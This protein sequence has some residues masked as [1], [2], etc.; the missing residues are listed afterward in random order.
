MSDEAEPPPPGTELR[1]GGEFLRSFVGRPVT[2]IMG[3]LAALVFGL[4]SYGNLPLNLM[5]DL[6]YP[7]ITVRAEV[8]GAAPEEVEQTLARPLEEALSTVPGLLR[9]ESESRAGRCDVILEFDWKSDM[10]DLAQTVRERIGLVPLP[11]GVRRPLVL[12]YDPN[13]DPI[14]RIAL[15]GADD[16]SA[17]LVRLR[18]IAEDEVRR[19]VESLPGIAAVVVKGGLERE[20]RVELDEGLLHA[21]G[22]WPADVVSRLEQENLN[23]A[24]GSLLEGQTEYL[25]RTLNEF[26]STDELLD[27]L[28][29]AR[30]G[31]SVRLGDVATITTKEKE[32]EVVGRMSGHEAVEIAIFREADA[33][34]VAVSRRVRDALFGT[35]EQKKFIEK[36]AQEKKEEDAGGAQAKAKED[37]AKGTKKAD[38]EKDGG[39]EGEEDWAGLHDRQ[40]GEFLANRLPTDLKLHVVVDQARYVE[41]AIDSVRSDALSGALLSILVIYLFLRHA[42]STLV[43]ASTIP[44]S[45]AATFAPLYLTGRSLNLMSLGGLALASGMLVDAAIVVL[46]SIAR[47]REEG[48]SGTEAAVRGTSEVLAAVISSTLTTVAVF[49]PI[50]F[51]GGMAG[52]L[53]VD[54]SMTVVYGLMA[55][56]VAAF[57]VIPV[58]SAM[59]APTLS[60]PSGDAPGRLAMLGPLATFRTTRD[61]VRGALGWMRLSAPRWVLA[62]ILLAWILLRSVLVLGMTLPIWVGLW[63]GAVLLRT[64]RWVGSRVL[65]LGRRFLGPIGGGFDHAWL[66][67]ETGYTRLV[68]AALRRP[69]TVIVVAVVLF[70]ATVALLPRVGTELLPQVHQGVFVAKLRL[71]VGTPLA[72]T[73]D[74]VTEVD[75]RIARLPGVLSVHSSAGAD[76]ETE[77]DRG[78]H[79]A[80]LTVTVAPNRDPEAAEDR[81]RALV[82]EVLA[83]VPGLDSELQTPTLFSFR[84]P[85]EVEVQGRDLRAVRE[86]ADAVVERLSHVEGLR[87]VRSNLG[88]GHPEVRIRYDR[89]RLLAFG[90]DV[91]T[92]ANAIRDKV[93]GH[94]A[95]DLPGQGRRTDVRVILRESDRASVEDLRHLNVN[96]RGS[97]SI[98][99]SSVAEL[100]V[101]EGPSQIR[102]ADQQRAAVV[103]ADIVGF[104]LGRAASASARALRS[105]SVPADVSV[106][107]GGQSKEMEASSRSLQYALWLATFLVYVI[108]ASQFENLVQPLVILLT[109]PLAAIGIIPALVLTG[110]PVSVLVLIGVI[111]LVGVVV[112]NAI[113]LVDCIF[114]LKERGVEAAEAVIEAG[115]LRLRP[116]MMTTLTT[117]FGLV[118][119]LLGS[120]E[121]AEL[122]RPLAI[123]LIAGMASSTALTLVFIPVLH[124]L[125]S[126]VRRA[127]EEEA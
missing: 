97:P 124:H 65:A 7:T 60:A 17:G 105:L 68:A 81:V 25:I 50:S 57:V 90:L 107:V 31:G 8:E 121:G 10:S 116:I 74:V 120:G 48:D 98:P 63:L 64:F 77:A 16:S 20:V 39:E 108:M 104:D 34:V 80:D 40:M 79:A 66:A 95:T 59:S 4:V 119:M 43:I 23:L 45:L 1:T 114:M 21:R 92:V 54:L 29:P 82:R 38:K 36:R 14:L 37:T 26:H 103:S 47:R 9:M 3:A 118:P 84:T 100:T 15:T 93:Q 85:L 86:V 125:T 102:R 6:S 76:L 52:Q 69:A 18:R 24:G 12:R 112:D 75:Q 127:P 33:N 110:T 11:D 117:G 19:A 22:L 87:D 51:L 62:P 41:A 53:F 99:L 71:P 67:A 44:L 27:V 32:R 46:E 28:V 106:I 2:V 122:R 101:E 113:V 70:S 56:M 123:T 13:L 91:Q 126:G 42:W 61:D 94:V 58:L 72:R 111:V 49:L 83:K 96:P 73:L 5:P 35:D 115:R 109:I 55:S 30:G 78:E 88:S 89:E